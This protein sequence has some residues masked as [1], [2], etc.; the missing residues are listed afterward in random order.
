MA[1]VYQMD[2]AKVKE[3]LGEKEKK[4]IMQDIAVKKAVEFVVEKAK[5]NK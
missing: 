5:E 3:L 2:V 1:E 4:N